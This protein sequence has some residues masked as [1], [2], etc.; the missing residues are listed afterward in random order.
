MTTIRNILKGLKLR[1]LVEPGPS[2]TTENSNSTTW[3]TPSSTGPVIRCLRCATEIPLHQF[4]AVQKT[5]IKSKCFMKK[6]VARE[7]A[8][9]IL[10]IHAD[11][12]LPVI[13]GSLVV[14]QESGGNHLPLG[15]VD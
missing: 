3:K 6:D 4:H 2:A 12:M 13:G 1:E 7:A 11:D 14:H 10:H 9:E 5:C 15:V 8:A